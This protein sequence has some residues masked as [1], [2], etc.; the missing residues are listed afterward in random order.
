MSMI[1]D[2]PVPTDI[3]SK[4]SAAAARAQQG[5][6]NSAVKTNNIKKES[7]LA[8][9]YLYMY[10]HRRKHLAMLL[11]T[12][13]GIRTRLF[14]SLSL[15]LVPTHP[16][17][18]P[19]TVTQVTTR[20]LLHPVTLAV[21]CVRFIAVCPIH[22]KQALE[23]TW[24]RFDWVVIKDIMTISASSRALLRTIRKRIMDERQ[25]FRTLTNLPSRKA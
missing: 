20:S 16:R 4:L 1:V 13:W 17:P 7:K 5:K 23:Q 12:H 18:I 14:L 22:Y 8:L 24:G 11:G 3:G 15:S 21:S 6:H 9:W 19:S 25:L 2:L 10:L